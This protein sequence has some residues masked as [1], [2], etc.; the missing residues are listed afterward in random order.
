[1]N[2]GF[3]RGAG[4]L[5]PSVLELI[6]FGRPP[7]PR[8]HPLVLRRARRPTGFRDHTL[9]FTNLLHFSGPSHPFFR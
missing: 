1:M 7:V 5:I 8:I 2:H 4:S 6:I 9:V 3:A